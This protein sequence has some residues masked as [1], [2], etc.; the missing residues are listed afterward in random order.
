M[1]W[2]FFLLILANAGF[3]AWQ[4][5]AAATLNVTEQPVYAPPVSERIYLVSETSSDAALEQ[6]NQTEVV[7]PEG[8][9]DKVAA[10]INAAIE[11]ASLATSATS[12]QLLCPVIVLERDADRRTVVSLLNQHQ[13]SFSQNDTTGKREKYW[14]Y[15]S[16]PSSSEAAKNIVARLK[17]KKIDSYVITRGE[18]KN[19]ISLGLYS[20]K[21][22]A[23]Q[24]QAAISERSGMLVNIYDHERTVSLYELLLANPI[25]ESDWEKLVGQLDMSKL[26]IKIEKNPC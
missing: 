5:F 6:R 21:T 11:K 15:I 24:A 14:L 1:K 20:S 26:L 2:L 19:R 3:V 10:Q 18:M 17:Q 16:A 22:R 12:E 9:A 23:E 7:E 13:L 4:G 25:P 8:S